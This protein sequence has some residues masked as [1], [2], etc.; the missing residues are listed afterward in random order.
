[1]LLSVF[2][3]SSANAED[4]YW[5]TSI[6][7]NARFPSA[8]AALAGM[9]AASQGL[10]R[11][12]LLSKYPT[13]WTYTTYRISDGAFNGHVS[14]T[15]RGNECP[16]GTEYN[17]ETGGCVAP[18]EPNACEA[19]NQVT[20]FHQHKSKNSVS[21]PENI[22]PP[23]SVCS[24]SCEYTFQYIVRD[25]YVYKSG[26]PPGV[27]QALEYK[28][29]GFECSENTHVNPGSSSGQQNPDETPSPDPE[30]KCPA[31]YVW[32]GTFCSKEPPKPCDPE[33]EVGGCDD[34]PPVNPDPGDGGDDG[35]G[36]DDE[37]DGDGNGDGSGG[38]GSGGDGD[39]SGGDS[40][41][42]GGDGN[43]DGKDEEEKPDSSV[44]GEACDS[45]LSC[46]GDAVQCAIL[47]KQ[48]EQ[49][50]M[51]QYGS[52]EKAQVET[53]L[54]GPDYELKE[55]TLPVSGLFL[56]AVN[57]GRW[58]PQSC[59]SPERFTVMGRQFEMSYELICRFATALGPLL[60]VMASIFFAVYVGR[61]FKG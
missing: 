13:Y 4:Y 56:E 55:E 58:L 45:T 19:T 9:E 11:F 35:E 33:V 2:L 17:E 51:W 5:V 10:S 40:D 31:G 23:G 3:H 39:G 22:P 37:G 43:G 29:N 32:N 42:S 34:T 50:C 12:E 41:G 14:I 18:E 53:T 48:K 46:E 1:M 54:S 6:T 21:D 28:G 52:L 30:N 15:R 59:P 20:I 26:E 44:G 49:V 57:K 16:S 36:G 24:G 38:D 25:V 27:F 60:V 47:R 7:G 61:A 8:V